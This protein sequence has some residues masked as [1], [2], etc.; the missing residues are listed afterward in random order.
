M[1]SNFTY[2]KGTCDK[3]GIFNTN[4]RDNTGTWVAVTVGSSKNYGTLK[5]AQRYM[6]K[7]G[8]VLV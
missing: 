2:L 4:S 7:N 3:G 6:A 1:K 8:Y 5:G